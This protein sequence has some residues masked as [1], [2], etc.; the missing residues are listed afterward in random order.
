M[1]RSSNSILQMS[2]SEEVNYAQKG[3]PDDCGSKTT[4]LSGVSEMAPLTWCSSKKRKHASTE[5][6]SIPGGMNSIAKSLR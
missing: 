1:K 5:K 6:K 4:I 2:V 3:T